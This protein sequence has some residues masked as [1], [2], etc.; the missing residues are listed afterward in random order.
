[1]DPKRIRAKYC[2]SGFVVDLIAVLPFDVAMAFAG[3][4]NNNESLVAPPKP[5]AWLISVWG[6]VARLSRLRL[7]RLGRVARLFRYS[8]HY[9]AVALASRAVVR[10]LAR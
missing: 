1:M 4:G 9:P 3:S 2:R 7:L 5:R 6:R 8:Q 10:A